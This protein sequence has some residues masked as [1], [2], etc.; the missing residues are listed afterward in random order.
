MKSK[1]TVLKITEWGT[2]QYLDDDLKF[3]TMRLD[4]FLKYCCE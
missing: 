1:Y 4:K 3:K 2:V